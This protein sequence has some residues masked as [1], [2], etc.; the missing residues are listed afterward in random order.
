MK[1]LIGPVNRTVPVAVVLLS[2]LIAGATGVQART[3]FHENSHHVRAPRQCNVCHVGH[4]AADGQM[5]RTRVQETVC[6]ACHAPSDIARWRQEDQAAVL[7]SPATPLL[8]STI[9][10]QPFRLGPLSRGPGSW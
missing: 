1:T 5:L 8:R 3:P 10:E 6:A 7:G 9:P 2:L 4:R